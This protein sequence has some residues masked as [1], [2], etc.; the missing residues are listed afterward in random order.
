[1]NGPA[2]RGDGEHSGCHE[3]SA[4]RAALTPP[5]VECQHRSDD[6]QW[7][8]DDAHEGQGE[9]EG[10][11]SPPPPVAHET[12]HHD[13][14][15]EA[16]ALAVRDPQQGGRDE[17]ARRRHADDCRP[18]THPGP[19]QPVEQDH[20]QRTGDGA[21][22]DCG[23]R[24]V[25][26]RQQHDPPHDPGVPRGKRPGPGGGTR[27][28]SALEVSDSGQPLV[29][30]AVPVGRDTEEAGVRGRRVETEVDPMCQVARL[31]GTAVWNVLPHES[32]IPLSNLAR[33]KITRGT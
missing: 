29:P 31:S 23:R 4:S 27:R 8:S 28:V 10:H 30:L 20:G 18:G 17:E 15:E 19:D 3:V 16:E 11:G 12:E 26:S 9:H 22:E 33:P 21:R 14:E 32:A 1:M 13:D 6:R 7:W 2:R 5:A 24:E 25:Q